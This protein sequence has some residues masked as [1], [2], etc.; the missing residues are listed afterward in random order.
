MDVLEAIM[1]RRISR[2]TPLPRI[3]AI[4]LLRQEL[5]KRAG[6]EKSACRVAAEQGIFCGGFAR[7]TDVELRR[8]YDWIVRR[9]PD[10]TR[11]ELE[12]IGDRWQMAR[13]DVKDLPI[14]CDVQQDEQH[15]CNGWNDFTNEQLEQFYYEMTGKEIVVT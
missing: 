5:V 7:Y 10:M 2:P 6:G 12:E 8:R 9:Y 4:D 14:A 13:Q 11:A 15:T 3:S 1:L